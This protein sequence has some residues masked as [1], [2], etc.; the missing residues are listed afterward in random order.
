VV[1]IFGVGDVPG[2]S[3]LAENLDCEW[4]TACIILRV[5][6]L[7]AFDKD[8]CHHRGCRETI[9][10]VEFLSEDAKRASDGTSQEF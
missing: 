3:R 7:I 6:I 9:P 8:S 2:I 1:G 5:G 10:G 4:A